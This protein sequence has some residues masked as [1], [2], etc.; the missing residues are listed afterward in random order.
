M[1]NLKNLEQ[2]KATVGTKSYF[3]ERSDAPNFTPKS[4]IEDKE[5]AYKPLDIEFVEDSVN[6]PDPNETNALGMKANWYEEGRKNLDFAKEEH[7]P[8]EEQQVPSIT[9]E[10]LEAIRKSAYDDGFAEGKEQ[11]FASGHKEGYEQ[12]VASGTKD[13]FVAGQAEGLKNGQEIVAQE[14]ARFCRYANDLVTPLSKL[15]TEIASELIYLAGRLARAF[16]K[17][18][19]SINSSYLEH[20]IAGVCKLLPVATNRVA[21][22]LNPKDC[23]LVSDTLGAQDIKIMPD[24]SLNPG[25]IAADAEM[26]SID[27]RLEERIDKFLAEFM[28]LNHDKVDLAPQNTTYTVSHDYDNVLLATDN[29][30][31]VKSA[32]EINVV[33]DEQHLDTAHVLDNESLNVTTTAQVDTMSKE[34][35]EEAVDIANEEQ[36]SSASGLNKPLTSGLS[37][38]RG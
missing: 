25:D 8:K 35:H 16:I 7:S 30:A 5:S 9:L 10:E 36:L 13:G 29:V 37:T 31:D 1:H 17:H 19:V 6:V 11:G 3:S 24:P 38:K 12:G 4:L 2:V 20:A 26:S 33:S 28:N 15:D 23:K 22:R 34:G 27:I 21:F 18:D 32:S 14:A